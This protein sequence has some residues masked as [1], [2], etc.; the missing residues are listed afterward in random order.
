MRIHRHGQAGIPGKTPLIIVLF[1][2]SLGMLPQASGMDPV[3][4]YMRIVLNRRDFQEILKTQGKISWRAGG[5][6][7][8]PALPSGGILERFTLSGHKNKELPK[9]LIIRNWADPALS[10]LAHPD[11]V[12]YVDRFCFAYLCDET[13]QWKRLFKES[14]HEGDEF[15]AAIEGIN[16]QSSII[17]Y[18]KGYHDE[19]GHPDYQSFSFGDGKIKDGERLFN[20]DH[21]PKGFRPFTPSREWITVAD[22]VSQPHPKWH[23]D[24]VPTDEEPLAELIKLTRVF[25]LEYLQKWFAAA[26]AGTPPAKPKK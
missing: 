13:G 24:G 20:P 26:A 5:G 7:A 6:T 23:H 4:D 22:Y 12:S 19:R 17:Y 21:W 2:C 9:L 25:S 8:G 10:E 15:G 16:D 14:Y 11:N 18:L 3:S 1:A